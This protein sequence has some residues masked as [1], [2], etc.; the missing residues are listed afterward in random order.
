MEI[1][2]IRE[3]IQLAELESYADAAE[4]MYI[5]QSSLFKHIKTLENELGIEL[6]VKKGKH[7]EL[8]EFGKV[9]LNFAKEIAELDNRSKKKIQSK[10]DI[11]EQ[12]IRIWTNY[13]IGDLAVGFHRQHEEYLLDTFQ[14]GY[15]P[16][17]IKKVTSEGQFDLYF[18]T[19]ISEVM[20]SLICMPYLH[21]DLILAVNLEHPLATRDEVDIDELSNENFILFHDFGSKEGKY[22]PHN[23][24]L[25]D[26]DFEPRSNM[27]LSSGAEIIKCVQKNA[28]VA[29]LSRNILEKK[30]HEGV[31]GIRI[32]QDKG[33]NVWC[34][35][36]KEQ[37]LSHGVKVLLEYCKNKEA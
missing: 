29:I 24:L 11:H 26:S 33:Y 20:D 35:Y 37:E 13:H 6:F 19:N 22:N 34:C 28:G 1:Q 3:F 30:A 4:K 12:K 17:Q 36:H 16:Q 27:R 15:L 9:Y 23:K 31:K 8:G 21:E 7:I 32:K 10:L 18:L 2:Y 14:G 5:S 25:T